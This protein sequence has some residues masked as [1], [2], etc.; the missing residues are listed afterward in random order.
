MAV[1]VRPSRVRLALGNLAA[2]QTHAWPIVLVGVDE[3]DAGGLGRL[4]QPC[5][6]ARAAAAALSL[7][8]DARSVGR[9]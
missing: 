6:A 5:Q 2:S 1:V 3:P 7:T 9:K 4:V 8:H